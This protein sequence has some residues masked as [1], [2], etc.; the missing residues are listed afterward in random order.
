MILQSERVPLIVNP[1][2]WQVKETFNQITLS[3]SAYFS[4]FIQDISVF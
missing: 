3:G 4:A 1:S 2:F